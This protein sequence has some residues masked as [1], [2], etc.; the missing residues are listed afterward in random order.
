MHS[1]ITKR[2]VDALEPTGADFYV[3]DTI[4]AGFAV[5]VRATGATSYIVQYKAGRGRGAATR[6]VTIGAVG[7]MT[8]HQAREAAKRVLAD[9]AQGNDPAVIR[10]EERTAATVAELAAAFEAGH[11]QRLASK[12]RQGYKLALARLTD[13]HG[14]VRA[15]ALTRAQVAAVFASIASPSSGNK[16][17]RCASALYSFGAKYGLIP[18]STI[19][20]A[21]RIKQHK[22]NKRVRFMSNAELARL[23]QALKDYEAIDPFPVAA[24]RLL[25]LTGARLHEIL[26][27]KWDYVDCE[28]AILNLPASKT[29]PRAIRLNSAALAV[30]ATIPRLA[31]HPFLFPGRIEGRPLEG[32]RW[33]WRAITRAAGLT[34]L[35]I[36]DLRHAFA[37][38]AVTSG[39]SLP[40]IQGLLGH[41]SPQMTSRYSH[42]VPDAARTAIETVGEAI[43]AALDRREGETEGG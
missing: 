39:V 42:L 7:K 16:F 21:S 4:L 33:P 41:A 2:L 28:R 30:L 32:L 17:L 5:R 9:V 22:E 38:C 34:D 24:I 6:R 31:G 40:A 27:A 3:W 19:N 12:T 14:R 35:H 13:A 37:S 8:P 23:G 15:D 36:H 10:A 18:E 43:S 20:P 29:G 11:M 1:H 26:W 25:L